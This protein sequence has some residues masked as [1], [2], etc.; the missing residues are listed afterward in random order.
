[1]DKCQELNCNACCTKE[2]NFEI[3]ANPKQIRRIFSYLKNNKLPIPTPLIIVNISEGSDQLDARWGF[4]FYKDGELLVGKLTLQGDK[5]CIYFNDGCTIYPVRPIGCRLYR[6]ERLG[7]IR[8]IRTRE[9]KR[10]DD[11]QKKCMKLITKWNENP[12]TL[13]QFFHFIGLD[14]VLNN[15]EDKRDGN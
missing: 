13:E 2:M 4:K 7:G 6:C 11:E 3:I 15:V 8:P 5:A 14:D 1:M 9:E 10:M 12:G